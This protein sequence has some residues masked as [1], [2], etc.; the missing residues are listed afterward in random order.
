[1]K[2]KIDAEPTPRS[3]GK[4][5]NSFFIRMAKE[6]TFA[7]SSM[8]GNSQ[9][10]KT[11]KKSPRNSSSDRQGFFERLSQ[12]DTFASATYKGKIE[13]DSGNSPSPSA[14]KHKTLTNLDF[15]DRL[16]RTET[17]SSRSKKVCYGTPAH[18]ENKNKWNSRPQTARPA[19]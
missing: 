10:G 8:K 17:K 14:K 4:T 12:S 2:G 3:S 19:P 16:S 18:D 15:F 11:A 7:S 9:K 13:A 6:D 1:M 5:T